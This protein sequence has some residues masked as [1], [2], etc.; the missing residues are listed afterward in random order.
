MSSPA[1]GPYVPLPA[2]ITIPIVRSTAM[3]V[4]ET[5]IPAVTPFYYAAISAQWI[6]WRVDPAV[7]AEYCAPLGLV[8]AI[9]DGQ[10]LVNINFFNAA[11]L[12]GSGQPGN[13]G[14]GGFNETEVNIVAYPKQ[15]AGKVPTLTLDEFLANGDQTKR[16]GNYRVW[17]ACD[18]EIAVLCGR[19]IYLENKI[20]TPYDYNVPSPNNPGVR[21]FTWTCHDP[22][23]TAQWIYRTDM[24]L[25]GLT[26][27]PGNMSEW[28][29]LSHDTTT[30]RIAGSRRNFFGMYDTYTLGTNA[31]NAVQMAYGDSPHAMKADM[32]KLIGSTPAYAVQV[33]RSPICIAE[34]RPYW[35]DE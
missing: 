34:A 23:T 25:A 20:L 15:S 29:D 11:A 21:T 12:Y 6:Y 16:I 1:G 18:N 22:D 35:A 8:P 7:L 10:G 13:P 24:N 32:Q 19:A 31:T 3:Q 9:F 2:T 26:P 5:T 27:T 14:V 4:G 33:Y 17:V 28:I 30:G